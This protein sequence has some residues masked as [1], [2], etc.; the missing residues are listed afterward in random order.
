MIAGVP[1]AIIG[2]T[3]NLVVTA[4]SANI[5]IPSLGNMNRQIL[6]TNLGTNVVFVEFGTS[7]VT[8]SLGSSKPILPN[9]DNAFSVGS[10]LTHLAAIASATGNTIYCTS[11]VG[12]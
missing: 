4:T 5:A 8:A 6:I 2:P 7:S 1:F 10:A 12:A 11:G 9:S 3:V